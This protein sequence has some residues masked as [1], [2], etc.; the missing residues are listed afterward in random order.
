ML[1]SAAPVS[2]LEKRLTH[3]GVNGYL[4]GHN[5]LNGSMARTTIIPVNYWLN[6][7][8]NDVLEILLHVFWRVA[9][10][11]EVQTLAI[12]PKYC[13]RVLL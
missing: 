6:Y 13:A 11:R 9:E 7:K 5:S 8:M 2:W 10:S 4:E 3:I 1:V 12:F